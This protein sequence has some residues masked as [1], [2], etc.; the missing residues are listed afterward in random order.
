MVRCSDQGF[1]DV[2]GY[3]IATWL[4]QK[5]DMRFLHVF[6]YRSNP[7]AHIHFRCVE[8]AGAFY[9]EMKGDKFHGDWPGTVTFL[10]ATDAANNNA[11]VVYPEP[12]NHYRQRRLSTNGSIMSL[13]SSASRLKRKWVEDSKYSLLDQGDIY[14]VIFPTMFVDGVDDFDF[15]ISADHTQITVYAERKLPNYPGVVLNMLPGK[16]LDMLLTFPSPVTSDGL[17]V[18]LDRGALLVWVKKGKSERVEKICK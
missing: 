14:L 6:K 15:E 17:E 9:H 8:D 1:I 18:K 2:I 12:R 4:H 10:P 3:E 13:D 16:K 7:F 11:Q 5:T